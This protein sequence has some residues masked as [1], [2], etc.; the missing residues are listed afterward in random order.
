MYF[1]D[2]KVKS[3]VKQSDLSEAPK[4]HLRRSDMIGVEFFTDGTNDRGIK[5]MSEG[6]F[7]VRR[8][9]GDKNEFICVRVTGGE[10]REQGQVTNFDVGYVIRTHE[11]ENQLNR[12]RGPE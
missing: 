10:S 12:E 5:D 3:G 9:Q 1:M 8:I 11:A 7:K 2:S 4:T 6:R